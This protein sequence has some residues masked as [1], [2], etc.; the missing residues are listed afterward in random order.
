MEQK[1]I[2]DLLTDCEKKKYWALTRE[3]M[4]CASDN[5]RDLVNN[6]IADLLLSVLRRQLPNEQAA[7]L[8]N[9]TL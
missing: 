5:E 6:D 4:F 2:R 3:L 9:T 8:E 1:R 7:S